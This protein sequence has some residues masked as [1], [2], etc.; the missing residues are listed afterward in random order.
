MLLIVELKLCDVIALVKSL[1]LLSELTTGPPYLEPIPI[2]ITVN[3]SPAYVVSKLY[4]MGTRF[5]GW[6]CENDSIIELKDAVKPFMLLALA[7]PIFD[8]VTIFHI[9][10]EKFAELL[11]KAIDTATYR[12][13]AP[14][15]CRLLPHVPE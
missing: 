11:E 2:N 5:R 1:P 3:E 9:A 15:L 14:R 6:H 8:N 12:E 4:P 10:R 7:C 13:H